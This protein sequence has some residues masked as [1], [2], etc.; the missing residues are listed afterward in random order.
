[1]IWTADKNA[2][3]PYNPTFT[4]WTTP[5]LPGIRIAYEYNPYVVYRYQVQRLGERNWEYVAEFRTLEEAQAFA[6]K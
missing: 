1:M 5:S 2:R 4:T 6:A 3:N